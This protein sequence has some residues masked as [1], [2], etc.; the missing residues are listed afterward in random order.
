MFQAEAFQWFF[1]FWGSHN[2]NNAVLSHMSR[3]QEPKRKANPRHFFFSP[4]GEPLF[5][6]PKRTKGSEQNKIDW[7]V[8]KFDKD[9]LEYWHGATEHTNAKGRPE[10]HIVVDPASPTGERP[11]KPSEH[12]PICKKCLLHEHGCAH[13]F[14]PYFG[15]KDPIVTIILD[16]IGRGEDENDELASDGSARNIRD[17]ISEAASETGVTLAD[18]RWV[19]MTRCANHRTKPVDFKSRGGWC[20]YHVIDDL[21]RNRPRLIIPVGTAALGLLSHK[22]NAQEWSGRLLTYRGWPDDW[23]T[24]ADYAH[25]RPHPADPTKTIIGHPV[26]GQVP[27]WRVPMVPIQSPR[28]IYAQQNRVVYKRWRN[29][30]IKALKMAK[31]GVRALSYERPWYRFS[32]DIGIIKEALND[33]LKHPGIPVCYD[34]ETTGLRQWMTEWVINRDNL[35][36]QGQVPE[37]GDMRVVSMMFRW[38]DPETHQPR[39]IGF[40]WELDGVKPDS[41]YIKTIAPLV[42]KVMT[43]STVIGHNLT[44]DMLFTWTTLDGYQR[45]LIQSTW[46]NTALNLKRD[47]LMCALADACAYDT[48]HMAFAW[49]QKRGSLGLE[50]MAYDWVPDLAGY[51]EDFVLLTELNYTKMHPA[52]ATGV[53]PNPHYLNCPPDK[54]QSH[55]MPYVMGDVEV[56]YRAYEKIL[57]KLQ[58]SNV[59]EIPVADPQNLGRFRWFTPPDR[60]WLYHNIMSPASRVLMKLMARG[61][62]IDVDAVKMMAKTMPVKIKKLREELRTADPRIEGWCATQPVGWELDLENK[63]QLKTLLFDELNLDVLRMTKA[64]KKKYGDNLDEARSRI[65]KEVRRAAPE[66]SSENTEEYVREVMK[67]FAAVDKFTLNKLTV[68]YPNLRP[69]RNYRKEFKLYS[70]Y[71]RPLQNIMTAGLDKKERKSDP[72]LCF[73]SCIHASFMLTGTR[74]GRLSCRDPNLQQL[75]RDGE[76]KSMFVSRFGPRGCVYQGDLSQIELRLLA[77]ISGDETMIKAYFDGI[78]L[79]SLTTSRIFGIPY[80]EATKDHVKLLQDKGHDKEAK[81]L[82]LIRVTAKTV[83]FLTGYGGGAFGLQNVLAMKDIDKPLEECEDIIASFFDSYPAIRSLLQYYKRF[84]MEAHVA[85]S[86]FGRVRVL[87]EVR[88]DDREAVAHALRAGC[89][90]LIQS[91]A[92]DMMLVALFVIE[93]LM[94]EAGLESMLVSTVHDSLVIDCIRAELSQVHQIVTDV[95]NNFPLVF[96]MLFGEDFDTSWMLVPFTGDCDVGLDYLNVRKIPEG[97]VEG[98]DWSKLLHGSPK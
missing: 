36:D 71:V 55:L 62:F 29:S 33:I 23:L 44:F 91:T 80:E 73:D 85:V 37:K 61:L 30:I 94:R 46:D 70:T 50:V 5:T 47:R 35:E 82:E 40:P 18:V 48:W 31:D 81:E 9:V 76:V 86:I 63:S 69:L 65:R 59:Y 57:D 12:S 24:D 32:D 83:N 72:H 84:I 4:T 7:R 92:S 66:L 16:S 54:W 2:H 20:R 88:S 28:L 60:N 3:G 64:G 78:D 96:K 8:D 49:Q 34:T 39:S 89:N 6:Q 22:S 98:I 25:E 21:N 79:H 74:G 26:F 19:P 93:K 45:R 67:D 97:D 56:A 1:D 14:M 42:W 43:K 51:E 58:T 90:H 38:V 87:E 41:D 77:A 17:I 10:F 52:S 11:L 53:G 68:K 75:P 27:D 95:L 15:P 13:P